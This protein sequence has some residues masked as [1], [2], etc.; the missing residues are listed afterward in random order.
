ML[1]AYSDASFADKGQTGDG[2]RRSHSGIVLLL[3]ACACLWKSQVQKSVSV[4]TCESELIA[5]SQTTQEVIYLR[6]LLQFLGFTQTQPTVIFEDNTAAEAIAM[7]DLTTERSRFIDTRHFFCKE[8]VQ[9]G[10]IK[11]VRCDTKV[12][13]ADLFTKFLPGPAFNDHWN[14][15]SGVVPMQFDKEAEGKLVAVAIGSS[16]AVDSEPYALLK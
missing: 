9:E 14:A 8:K 10:E 4:S 16:D 15:V 11:V 3:N 12:Q 13:R 2:R 5:L 6:R 1:R 7:S